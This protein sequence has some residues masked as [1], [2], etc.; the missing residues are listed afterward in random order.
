MI[1]AFSRAIAGIVSPSRSM[2]SRSTLVIDRHAAVPGVGRVEPP[3]E[4]DLDERHVDGRASANQRE[5]DRG[6]QLELGR[7]AVAPRD[8]V[9]ERRRTSPTSRAN[10]AGSIGRPSICRSA[11]GT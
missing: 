9:G 8:P 2:W 1:A 3:A 11:R 7:L 10:V 4:P 5:D 6:Q